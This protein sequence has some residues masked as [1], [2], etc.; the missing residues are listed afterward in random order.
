MLIVS[1]DMKADMD[2]NEKLKPIVAELFMTGKKLNILLVFIS[3]SHFTMPK[4]IRLNATH[5]FIMKI[6][7]FY[8]HASDLDQGVVL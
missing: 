7:V 5:Y 3:K 6:S 4:T 1:D 8:T 2:V